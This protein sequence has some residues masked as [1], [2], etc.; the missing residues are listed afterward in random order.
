M[1]E[2]GS[3][4]G[5]SFKEEYSPPQN[6][7]ME[8]KME[9]GALAGNSEVPERETSQQNV[10]LAATTPRQISIP[11]HHNGE[12]QVDF[13]VSLP[14][15]TPVL[16]NVTNPRNFEDEEEEEK[17]NSRNRVSFESDDDGSDFY[18]PSDISAASIISQHSQHSGHDS[19]TSIKYVASESTLHLRDQL[20]KQPSKAVMSGRR[21]RVSL[22][23]DLE[24]GKLGSRGQRARVSE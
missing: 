6:Q 10:S 3:S 14:A 16:S 23:M 11:D 1:A 15:T 17:H 22:T 20:S 12:E 7:S 19:L 18:E 13:A 21:R 2:T 9:A 8:D 24:T 4:G 5:D